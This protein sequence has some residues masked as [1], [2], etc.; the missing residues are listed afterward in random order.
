MFG[1][2][3]VVRDLLDA[4]EA[5]EGDSMECAAE[6]MA[7]ALADG[8][9]L[10]YFGAGHSHVLGDELFYRAG[11]LVPV[12]AIQESALMVSEGASKSTKMEQLPG[13][14]AII[15]S[16]SEMKAGDVLIIAS[17]SGINQV[18]VEMAAEAQRIGV[19]VIALTSVN[20][21]RSIPVRNSLNMRL[22]E[23]ADVVIDT[24]VPHGDAAVVVNGVEQRVGPVSTAIG[25]AIVNALVVS[26]V[27]KLARR[28]VEPPV[29]ASANVPGGAEHNAAHIARYKPAIK[30]L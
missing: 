11:G 1:Y 28:G 3:D 8:R 4:V 14:A 19:K 29:F 23:C 2:F 6:L 30:A 20:S 16:E 15:V 25:V 24:H 21:S 17:N 10:H 9:I 5:S 7:A 22:L 13:L 26:V 18:P 27:E 12:N